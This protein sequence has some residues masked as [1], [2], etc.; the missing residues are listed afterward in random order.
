MRSYAHFRAPDVSLLRATSPSDLGALQLQDHFSPILVVLAP[1]YWIHDSAANLLVAQGVLFA[2]AIPPLWAA[3]ASAT[4]RHRRLPG[5]SCVVA[6]IV[7]WPLQESG[8]FEFHEAA[9][10]V[11]TILWMLERANA[12]RWRQSLIPAALL[13]LV[14]EDMGLVVAAFGVVMII[15]GKRRLAVAVIATSLATLVVLNYFVLSVPGSQGSSYGHAWTWNKLGNSPSSALIHVIAH[16]AST[17]TIFATPARIKGATVG[18]LALMVLCTCVLSPFALLAIPLIAERFLSDNAFYWGE[19]FHYN[20]YLVPILFAAGIEG[21][22]R[23][24]KFR[25]NRWHW[26]G[27]TWA[28]AIAVVGIAVLPRFPFWQ[29]TR[30]GFTHTSI[31]TRTAAIDAALNHVPDNAIVGVDFWGLVPHLTQRTKPVVLP[32]TD[33]APPWMVVGAG[34]RVTELHSHGYHVVYNAH[35]WAVL[36]LP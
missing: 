28:A 18:W 33:F 2:L 1:L 9:F 23:L 3:R 32:H 35:G 31:D 25:W 34:S 7:A 15:R 5:G 22:A 8:N 27:L 17:L 14:K 26:T 29:L 12:S 10:A 16:P 30:P 21:A 13:F 24:A 11:P 4:R 19:N 36:H 6:Y 20:T